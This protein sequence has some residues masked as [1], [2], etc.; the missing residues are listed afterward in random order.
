[1]AGNNVRFG[2]WLDDHVT[3]GLG[4]IRDEFDRLGKSKGAKSI[5]QGVGMGAGISAFN[6]LGSAISG[7]VSVMQSSVQAAS[8]QREAMALTAQVFGKNTEAVDKWSRSTKDAFSST[9]AMTFAATFGTAFKSVGLQLDDVTAK[10]QTMVKLAGDLG[11]AFNTSSEEA[12]TALRSGLIGESEPM[13]RFG[14]FL[15]EAA[16]QAKAV[17]MGIAKLGDKLTDAQKVTARYQIIMDQTTDSQG[18]FGRDSE[19]LADKQKLL[20]TRLEDASATLGT[21]FTPYVM[22]ATESLIDLMDALADLPDPGA[23][24]DDATS[25]VQGFIDT[26][27]KSEFTL[28]KQARLAA[29]AAEEAKGLA[30]GTDSASRSL[31]NAGK[32]GDAAAGG[33]GDAG[34]AA[35]DATPRVKDLTHGAN[36]AADAFKDL[37]EWARRAA[38]ALT[39][40]GAETARLEFSQ[41]KL[42]LQGNRKALEEVTDRIQ[43]LKDKGKPVP[44]ELRQ[45]FID[46]RLAI[47]EGETETAELGVKLRN[48][49]QITFA[50]L[51]EQ[52]KRLGIKLDADTVKALRLRDA[53][54]KGTAYDNLGRSSRR[55]NRASGGPVLPGWT[56]TVGEEG[57]ERLVMSPTG[58]GYVIPNAGG[59]QGGG[60]VGVPVSIPIILDGREIAR[61]VDRHLYYAAARAP[62]SATAG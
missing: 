34:D 55:G 43:K 56:Y 45:Q 25:G 46:L 37:D 30:D 4:K 54:D 33:I 5:L 18:M 53:I 31:R 42:E 58:G 14:V 49:G 16:V 47:Q 41:A 29:K 8:D 61:V 40:N 19:S 6:M 52:L 48:T 28:E 11:S 44:R 24:W 23:W 35:G 39:D 32:A 10:S 38:E 17:S 50:D 15:S 62:R 36:D 51:I 60:A 22:T 26:L 57:P 1:M 12:A 2:A 20:N 13:R 3:K 21:K 27:P 9:E 59:S 7:A